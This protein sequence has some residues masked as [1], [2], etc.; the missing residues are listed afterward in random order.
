M[1]LHWTID[2]KERLFSATAEGDVTKAEFEAYLDT[3]DGADL[4]A[5]RKLFDGLQAYTTMGMENIMALG[6]RMRASHQKAAVGAL[7]I[8]VQEDKVPMFTRV[9]GMLAAANRPMR[10]FCDLAAAR[11]WIL[12]QPL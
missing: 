5:W 11:E 7:A 8:A 12:K 6:V 1:P 10:V 4:H 2:S 3:I 9:L